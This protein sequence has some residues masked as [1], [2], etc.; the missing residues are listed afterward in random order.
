M[1]A[2][3]RVYQR[4]VAPMSDS[5]TRK[6][7]RRAI[8]ETPHSRRLLVG[9][10]IFRVYLRRMRRLTLSEAVRASIPT[11]YDTLFDQGGT[12][13]ATKVYNEIRPGNLISQRGNQRGGL[14]PIARL[15]GTPLSDRAP[16][17]VARQS[18]TE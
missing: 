6:V 8:L 15:Q 1:K 7:A 17:E 18:G 5:E 13:L 11:E 3:G 12:G 2:A 4:R 10:S 9:G 16:L 14:R